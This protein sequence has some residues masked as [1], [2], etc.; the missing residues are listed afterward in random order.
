MNPTTRRI[1]LA[2]LLSAAIT[3]PLA[4]QCPQLMLRTWQP[5]GQETWT[6]ST[7]GVVVL[8]GQE[9]HVYL[10]VQGR[11]QHGYTTSARVGYPQEYGAPG[12]QQDVL[13]HV[14]MV[15]P[16]QQDQQNG[17]IRFTAQE[18]G[19]TQLG[20]MV[21]AV[22]PPG[23]IDG[24]P[25]ACRQGLFSVEVRP[26]PVA[27]P[28]TGGDTGGRPGRPDRPT[29][30]DQ[31]IK[32]E[33]QDEKYKR[34][35]VAIGSDGDVVVQEQLSRTRCRLN[36]TFGFDAQGIWVQ[37]GCRA[38]FRVSPGSVEDLGYGGGRQPR[39]ITC[40][41][42]DNKRKFCPADTRGGVRVLKKH[43]RSDCVLDYSWGWDDRG[44]WVDR[45]CR[46][47]FEIGG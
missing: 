26:R 13:R 35:Q 16:N 4:A 38:V 11:S 3:A 29:Q 21:T 6:S 24:L 23:K 7:E 47:E 34:C 43:S 32:C 25:P 17:R 37:G 22:T 8:T 14:R 44:I 45:G 30:P 5:G 27:P 42:Q 31:Y 10:H 1:G 28:S 18:P 40:E 9:A 36:D 41:S 2:A 19:R 20:Y 46:A 12:R 39:S 33:S 15:A